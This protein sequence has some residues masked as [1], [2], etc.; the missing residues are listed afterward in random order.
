M[1]HHPG[2]NARR[3]R[4]YRTV[5]ARPP[6]LGQAE[7][8]DQD[9]ELFEQA[10]HRR[11]V[12]GPG[13]FERGHRSEAARLHLGTEWIGMVAVGPLPSLIGRGEVAERPIK[14]LNKLARRVDIAIA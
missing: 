7:G 8:E 5:D 9:I 10:S 6:D 12:F 14:K 1:T 2:R 4:E 11:Q 13:G 3:A